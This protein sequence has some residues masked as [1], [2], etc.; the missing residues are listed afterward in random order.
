MTK[1]L[2]QTSYTAD[3]LKGLKKDKATGRVAAIKRAIA[4]AGGKVEVACWSFGDWDAVMV[5]DFPDDAD[6]LALVLKE[7]ESG[8]VRTKTTVL[9]TPEEM[10]RAIA[11]S[12]S[13][14]APG[15]QS[16]KK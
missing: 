11:K 7:G 9:I 15:K 4:S 16:K 1:Y 2:I 13:Y 12:V 3:G 14:A 8:L 10:D 6:A 5:L